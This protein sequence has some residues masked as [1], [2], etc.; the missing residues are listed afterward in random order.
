MSEDKTREQLIKEARNKYYRDY[1]KSSEE[2][3]AKKKEYQKRYWE[4]KALGE[5]RNRNEL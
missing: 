3:K 2:R 5:W 4:K 1:Y